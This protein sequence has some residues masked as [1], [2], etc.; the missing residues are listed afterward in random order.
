MKKIESTSFQYLILQ[1]VAIS[2]AGMVLWPLLDLFWC[3][4][5]SHTQFVYSIPD[6][7]VEPIVFGGIVGTVFWVLEKKKNSK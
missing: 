7:L 3:A 6:H 1:I 5:L 2:V 4:V